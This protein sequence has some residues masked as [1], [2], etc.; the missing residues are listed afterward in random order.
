MKAHPHFHTLLTSVLG[1]ALSFTL[2]PV[3][4]QKPL[5]QNIRDW[6]GPRAYLDTMERNLLPLPRIEALFL[7]YGTYNLALYRLSS[8]NNAKLSMSQA[9]ETSRLPHFL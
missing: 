7:A 1:G 4:L 3:N 8:L 5:E 6:T 2:Q 9:V